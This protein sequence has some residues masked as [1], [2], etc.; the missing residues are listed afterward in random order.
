LSI[1]GRDDLADGL[2]NKIAQTGSFLDAGAGWGA[3]MHENLAGID[4]WEE[5]LAKERRQ[6]E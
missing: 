5:I 3:D 6:S 2:L 1:A 4:G